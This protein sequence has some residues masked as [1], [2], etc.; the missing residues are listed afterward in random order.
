MNLSE[1]K[2]TGKNGRILKEDILNFVES[3][4]TKVSDIVGAV[5]STPQSSDAGP[6]GKV[7]T[8]PAVRHMA[9][10]KGV[11]LSDVRGT[12]EEGRILKED[13]LRYIVQSSAVGGEC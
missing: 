11:N 5:T 1:V 10:E 7:L 3:V 6:S 8:T 9:K 13:L 4:A 2:G 12:G